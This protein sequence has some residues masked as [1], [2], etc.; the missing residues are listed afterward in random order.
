MEQRKK[1]KAAREAKG[2]RE[3]RKITQQDVAD[4][5]GCNSDTYSMWERG[6]VAP[7][8]YYVEKLCTYYGTKDPRDLDLA[9]YILEEDILDALQ[10]Y[11]RRTLIAMLQGLPVFAGVD[12]LALIETPNIAPGE[13]LAQCNTAINACWQLLKH[14]G[15]DAVQG[16]LNTHLPKLIPLTTVP[17][18]Q[19]MAAELAVQAEILQVVLFT[20]RMDFSNAQIAC[21]EA[22]RYGELTG[23]VRLLSQA[24]MYQG[25]TYIIR[26]MPMPNRAIPLFLEALRLINGSAAF[27]QQCDASVCLATAYAIS[28]NE[29]QALIALRQA[30]TAFF[31]HPDS[32]QDLD[33]LYGH[34]LPEFSV[35]KGKAFL[36]LAPHF[37]ESNYFQGAYDVFASDNGLYTTRSIANLAVLQ[38][39]A[40]RGLGDMDECIKHLE[41]GTHLAI[42]IDSKRRMSEASSV[43]SRIPEKWQHETVI[44]NLQKDLSR[45]L[46]VARR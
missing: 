41:R 39:D 6:V 35:Q 9:T 46:V 45:S 26:P 42:K 44:R 5:I 22:V 3:R 28:G 15:F 32:R 29:T 34:G 25:Y 10:Y 13:I 38:A 40:A 21:T 14:S 30:E 23:D 19:D 18:Y 7:Q 8:A 37:P 27:L 31:A 20:H 1:L 2:S 33:W 43:I 11:D 12:L 36:H 16:V 24:L 17:K 4:A